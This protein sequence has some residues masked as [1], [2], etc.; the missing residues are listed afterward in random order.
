MWCCFSV[1]VFESDR[2]FLWGKKKGNSFWDSDW[3]LWI[4]LGAADTQGQQRLLQSATA[5]YFP[6]LFASFCHS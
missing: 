6:W 3:G 5:P 1:H 2:T 4:N